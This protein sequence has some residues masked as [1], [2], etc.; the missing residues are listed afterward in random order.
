MSD[1]DYGYHISELTGGSNSQRVLNDGTITELGTYAYLL[2]MRKIQTGDELLAEIDSLKSQ[3]ASSADL[4]ALNNDL[5]TAKITAFSAYE[6]IFSL[7]ISE[8]IEALKNLPSTSYGANNNE[9]GLAKKMASSISSNDIFTAQLKNINKIEALVYFISRDIDNTTSAEQ[10]IQ[11]K[12][13]FEDANYIAIN[14][15]VDNIN[16]S[17]QQI[18]GKIELV[19]M[20]KSN[21]VVQ[22]VLTKA[23]SYQTTAQTLTDEAQTLQSNAVTVQD[24]AGLVKKLDEV[25]STI[26][27]RYPGYLDK[28]GD[29][30]STWYSDE[31]GLSNNASTASTDSLNNIISKV[32]SN[33]IIEINTEDLLAA[34]QFDQATQANATQIITSH[35]LITVNSTTIN[36]AIT[37]VDTI[38][39]NALSVYDDVLSQ[40][41]DMTNEQTETIT[42]TEQL[43]TSTNAISDTES[44]KS[45]YQAAMDLFD[46][47]QEFLSEIA[48]LQTELTAITDFITNASLPYTSLVQSLVDYKT[49]IEAKILA[50][51]IIASSAHTQAIATF[52]AAW[53]QDANLIS[54]DESQIDLTPYYKLDEKGRPTYE[55]TTQLQGWSCVQ[56]ADSLLSTN[57]IW[58]LL[59]PGSDNQQEGVNYIEAQNMVSNANSNNLCGQTD[60]V[61]PSIQQLVSLSTGVAF[62]NTYGIDKSV[63]INHIGKE[64]RFNGNDLSIRYGYW[65]SQADTLDSSKQQAYSYPDYIGHPGQPAVKASIE[66]DTSLSP[67]STIVARLY[68]EEKINPAPMIT[69]LDIDGRRA[70]ADGSNTVCVR[71]GNGDNDQV[72]TTHHAEVDNNEDVNGTDIT[73]TLTRLSEHN[74]AAGLCGITNWGLPTAQQLTQL[75]S[76]KVFNFTHKDSGNSYGDY[77]LNEVDGSSRYVFDIRELEISSSAV[78]A[79]SYSGYSLRAIGTTSEPIAD[80][81]PIPIAPSNTIEDDT[82]NTF[83][84]TYVPGFE[85]SELYEYSLDEGISWSFVTS[86]PQPIGDYLFP[87]GNVQVRVKAAN[88]INNPGQALISTSDYSGAVPCLGSNATEIDGTCYRLYTKKNWNDAKLFCE[89]INASL[90]SKEFSNFNIIGNNLGLNESKKYWLLEPDGSSYAYHFYNDSSGNW[91]ATDNWGSTSTSNTYE[92]ICAK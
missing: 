13:I 79:S 21:L 11:A 61:L 10:I 45:S 90:V 85:T 14:T 20:H 91:K 75:T 56:Q 32:S 33:G 50:A 19:N 80:T 40:E 27:T 82:N 86:N 88:G 48:Q 12:A 8:A 2:P 6:Q 34:T 57:R 41:Q 23:S 49:D 18:N 36:N 42:K 3:L 4:E 7:N 26:G 51:Q 46:K 83:G 81:L 35:G 71:I 44:A 68:R 60:W 54:Q 67:N 24:Y 17:T 65:S 5:N 30:T 9:L 1:S 58:S 29:I 31:I 62:T 77:W 66:N 92:F 78:Y 37:A 52:D 59:K 84:W 39:E 28:L 43:L 87:S 16:S 53:I 38:S 55:K 25:N 47:E 22:Q 72:W 89:S 64:S 63:F 76:D 73:N 74:A 69:E 15:L 70:L